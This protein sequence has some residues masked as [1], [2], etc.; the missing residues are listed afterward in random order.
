M[1][2]FL[3]CLFAFISSGFLVETHVL[4]ICLFEYCS[5]CVCNCLFDCLLV[6]LYCFVCL[7]AYCLGV[8]VA[9]SCVSLS[10]L[11]WGV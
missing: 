11:F 7:L 5:G 8:V 3:F 1:I 6:C 10:L 9:V 4:C 2:Q